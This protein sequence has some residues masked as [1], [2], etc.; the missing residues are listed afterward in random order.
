M[1]T[2]REENRMDRESNRQDRADNVIEQSQRFVTWQA[3]IWVVAIVTVMIGAL[4]A[5]Q[6]TIMA[7]LSEIKVDVVQI[8]T[9]M[10]W[11]KSAMNKQVISLK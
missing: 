1:A 4:W 7:S 10:A 9:D 11:V 8:K 3:F 6:L 5:I 2:E